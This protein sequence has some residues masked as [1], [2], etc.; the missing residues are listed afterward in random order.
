MVKVFFAKNENETR[1]VFYD[2]KRNLASFLYCERGVIPT[3]WPYVSS[4]NPTRIAHLKI[5]K[6][7]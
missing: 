5:R 6:L 1:A 2:T 3:K 4:G 7:H